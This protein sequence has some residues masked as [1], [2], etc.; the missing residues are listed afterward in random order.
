VSPGAVYT[1]LDRLEAKGFVRSRL[2]EDT[3]ARGGRRKK[4]YRLEP[5]GA[6][7]LQASYRQVRQ[8]AEGLLPRLAEVAKGR[9]DA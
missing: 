9:G 6:A 1:A 2:G 5:A 3:P 4:F 8:M 7:A